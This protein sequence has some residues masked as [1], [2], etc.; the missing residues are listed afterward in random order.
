MLP[1]SKPRKP[2]E[3]VNLIESPCKSSRN[4]SNNA[5]LESISREKMS[6]I[7]KKNVSTSTSSNFEASPGY[8][9]FQ[10]KYNELKIGMREKWGKRKKA[11]RI[12]IKSEAQIVLSDLK[13]AKLEGI[14]SRKVKPYNLSKL[15]F[16]VVCDI[17]IKLLGGKKVVMFVNYYSVSAINDFFQ[18]MI[19]FW[20]RL[21]DEDK[22]NI[23]FNMPRY[24]EVLV[25]KLEKSFKRLDA[26]PNDIE[27]VYRTA[28]Y[29]ESM[30]KTKTGLTRKQQKEYKLTIKTLT[31]LLYKNNCAVE[32]EAL[33]NLRELYKCLAG[34]DGKYPARVSFELYLKVYYYFT[35]IFGQSRH[36]CLEEMIQKYMAAKN[37]IPNTSIDNP[38]SNEYPDV[39][40]EECSD[41]DSDCY[42]DLGANAEAADE[43][44][45]DDDFYEDQLDQEHNNQAHVD[46]HVDRHVDQHVD[47]HVDSKYVDQKLV[48]QEP[49][50]PRRSLHENRGNGADIDEQPHRNQEYIKEQYVHQN[51]DQKYIDRVHVRQEPVPPRRSLHQNRCIN[52]EDFDVQK[53]LKQEY[54]DRNVDQNYVD[55]VHVRQEPVPP[56]RSLHQNRCINDEDFDAQQHL[57]QEYFDR[58]VDQKYIDRAH[59][60]QE[61]IPPRS[62]N[63]NRCNDAYFDEQHIKQNYVDHQHV[64]QEPVPPRRS[65]HQNRCSVEDFD[66]QRHPNRKYHNQEYI[67]QHV[68]QKYIDHVQIREEPVLPR[69]ILHQNRCSDAD[70]DEQH[71]PNQD[72]HRQ[73]Y[74]DQNIAQKY[75]DH[76]HVRQE[77][78]RPRILHQN[79]RI[80]EDFDE[81]HHPN[82][83]YH[84]QE[85]VDQHIAEKYIDHVRVRQEPVP[86]R[87]SLHQSRPSRSI[88]PF[89]T[90]SPRRFSQQFHPEQSD[91]S[92]PGCSRTS[93]SRSNQ[94][95]FPVKE[96]A[97]ISSYQP[98]EFRERS[99]LL[100]SRREDSRKSRRSPRHNS[101]TSHPRASETSHPRAPETSHPRAPEKSNPRAPES[102][103][104]LT[105]EASYLV[106]KALQ[107][108][109]PHLKKAGIKL[110]KLIKLNR[111]Q[112][113]D[114]EHLKHMIDSERPRGFR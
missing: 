5:Q 72:Y 20:A 40:F 89:Q 66:E 63:Q 46:Q 78:V 15:C 57:K 44:C 25:K 93:Q 91:Y 37:D 77:P 60:R 7:Q 64:R 16:I 68:A 4:L 35:L 34:Q 112:W 48:R 76:V 17:C 92:L 32:Q 12:S 10:L 90:N 83:E 6:N 87:R 85:Y 106:R 45:S 95:E 24:K 113:E 62:L 14:I 58:N 38:A 71:H 39:V 69:R 51:V 11:S 36:P 101:K 103:E 70:F 23:R 53:H 88:S 75:I 108:N 41:D 65:L 96:S 56:I 80:D 28:Q 94:I 47:Q 27:P 18:K 29:L 26:L 3:V 33:P 55:R 109:L 31:L 50:P 105:S 19:C 54:F 49:I 22:P 9:L 102:S 74:I 43:E 98:S 110:E 100:N 30:L 86:L 8:I 84:R 13:G 99:P 52:D 2:V 111:V 67:D 73:E 61:P 81:Q 82:Q 42:T 107:F 21:S 104:K 97:A 114:I 59:V 79:I 1:I